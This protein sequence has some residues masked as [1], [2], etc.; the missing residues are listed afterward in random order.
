[1]RVLGLTMPDGKKR[2]CDARCH[3]SIN[4][5]RD[6]LCMGLLRGRGEVFAK[7][8]AQYVQTYIHKCMAYKGTVWLNP[9]LVPH[10]KG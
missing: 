2:F 4:P 1:M 3:N 8:G 9:R 10:Y 5:R 6:C 7:H